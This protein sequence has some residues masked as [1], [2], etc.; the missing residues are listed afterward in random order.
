MTYLQYAIRL[1]LKR[2]QLVAQHGSYLAHIAILNGLR[3]FKAA[4]P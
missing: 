2:A 4:H 1:E 3:A